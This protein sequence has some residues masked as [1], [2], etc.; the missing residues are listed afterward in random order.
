MTSS[1]PKSIL[2]ALR[3]GDDRVLSDVYTLANGYCIRTLIRKTNCDKED[4]EDLFMDSIL[5]FR[6]NAK[7]GK[8]TSLTNLNSYMFGICWNLWREQNRAKT[9]WEAARTDIE[10]QILVME[11]QE[12]FPFPGEELLEQKQLIAQVVTAL[13]ELGERCKRL[14]TY[15]Y[16]DKRSQKDI[17][18]LMGFS[19]ANVVKVTRH[20]CY[21]QWRKRIEQSTMNSHES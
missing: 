4:A 14:L 1:S 6:D 18:E 9:K 21:Q 3:N 15:V 17:A 2:A 20:R 11:T 7:K 5:I 13:N 16:V 8:L 19:S 10:H 12:E